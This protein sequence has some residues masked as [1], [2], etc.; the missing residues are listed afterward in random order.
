M[1]NNNKTIINFSGPSVSLGPLRSDLIHLY[2]RWNNDFQTTRTLSTT[3]PVIFE[4]EKS[5]FEQVY[6]SREYIFFT[7]YEKSTLTPIC[8]TFLSNVD[9]KN[10]TAEFNIVIGE[11]TSR[12]KGYG[13]E[14]ASLVL[15]YAFIV[16]G[17]HNV[18]LK[19]YEFNKGAIRAYEK[20]G[21]KKC[22]RRRQAHYMYGKFWDVIFMDALA[23]DFNSPVLLD[24]LLP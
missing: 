17:L 22:G 13:T 24:K 18:F 9:Y 19:V 2:N 11:E 12:G 20:A 10:R 3:R 16:A 1:E 6:Q 8:N 21:F 5:A 15:D 23:A 4:E 14:V 7:I